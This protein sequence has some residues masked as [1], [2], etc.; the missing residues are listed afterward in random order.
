MIILESDRL[1]V[2]RYELADL[3]NF[4][5]LNSDPEV[6]RYIRPVKTF[7][8]SR[9]F[10]NENI[11]FYHLHPGLGRWALLNKQND[12]FVGSVSLLPLE[13]SKD[14]HIG[15]ALLKPYWGFGY[16]SEILKAGIQYA[17]EALKLSSLTAVTYP[18]NLASQKV[19]LKNGFGFEKTFYQDGSENQL[20][21]LSNVDGR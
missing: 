1:Y 2:R 12:R 19:L 5:L 17:F 21:R 16:A 4:H 20:Y 7:E 9:E 3:D 10:L 8:E 11:S 13:Y 18:E 15:Y 14:V 6:M